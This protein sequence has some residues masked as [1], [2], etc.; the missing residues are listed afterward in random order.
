MIKSKLNLVLSTLCILSLTPAIVQAEACRSASESEADAALRYQARL[1]VV[2]LSCVSAVRGQSLYTEYQGFTARNQDLLGE[3]QA[4]LLH[5][6]KAHGKGDPAN[7]LRSRDTELNN[8]E[9][10][11]AAKAGIVAFCRTQA[12]ELERAST[13]PQADVRD[14]IRAIAALQPSA[15][16]KC[17]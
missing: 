14:A 6:Y 1:R 16:G 7:R 8:E 3:Y 11:D 4:I 5:Y 17:S 15:N 10:L 13:E 9:S 12:P 2:A